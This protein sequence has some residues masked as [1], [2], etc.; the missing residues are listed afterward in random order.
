[1]AKFILKPYF[2]LTFLNENDYNADGDPLFPH[3]LDSERYMHYYLQVVLPGH[4][5]SPDQEKYDG[6]P[7]RMV[8]GYDNLEFSPDGADVI[9]TSTQRTHIHIINVE[10]RKVESLRV[11]IGAVLGGRFSPCGTYFATFCSAFSEPFQMAKDKD[12]IQSDAQSEVKL[13]RKNN[14]MELATAVDNLDARELITGA[15]YDE[16]RQ[17]FSS[18]AF[19]KDSSALV[20]GNTNGD[21][22][23]Y[24]IP[25]LNT[26][27]VIRG[28]H[29]K[30]I[31]CIRTL[32]HNG[33]QLLITCSNGS[34][35]KVWEGQGAKLVAMFSNESGTTSISAFS[36][37]DGRL[38]IQICDT[39]GG[40][41]IA[42]VSI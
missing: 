8:P 27:K 17:G 7:E 24:S 18:I 11:H 14:L 36:H 28:A 15:K 12:T 4:D 40:L 16:N 32:N 6:W 30:P 3:C 34:K 35:V 39:R 41:N 31:N 13:F 19:L 37:D 23:L 1:M 25:N 38:L 20:A 2:F 5:G 29:N 21:V 22:I 26:I 42:E 33:K 10:S 9:A